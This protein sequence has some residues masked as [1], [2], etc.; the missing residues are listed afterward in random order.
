MIHRNS[1]C[2][3]WIQSCTYHTRTRGDMFWLKCV[4]IGLRDYCPERSLLVNS[5]LCIRDKNKHLYKN[6]VQFISFILW[7]HPADLIY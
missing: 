2:N 4:Y 5:N 6:G 1:V 7:P 3:L